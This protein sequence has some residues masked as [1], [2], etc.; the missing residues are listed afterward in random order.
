MTLAELHVLLMEWLQKGVPE[1]TSV[2]ILVEH[3]NPDKPVVDKKP[4]TDATSELENV[5]LVDID[6]LYILP[7]L[8]SGENTITLVSNIIKAGKPM[9][10]GSSPSK[11]LQ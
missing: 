10:F 8:V 5:K 1:N 2:K 7:D 6:G 9:A 3:V 4:T 11:F